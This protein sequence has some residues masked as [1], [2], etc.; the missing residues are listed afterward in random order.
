MGADSGFKPVCILRMDRI[1]APLQNG[2]SQIA[3]AMSLMLVCGYIS[4]KSAG[5][6]ASASTYTMP[7]SSSLFHCSNMV[8][9]RSNIALSSLAIVPMLF[10]IP[11]ICSEMSRFSGLE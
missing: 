6:A 1:L 3:S 10:P 11:L 7:F 5:D 9:C 2:F 4:Q 8:A